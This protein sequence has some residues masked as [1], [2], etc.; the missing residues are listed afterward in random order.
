MTLWQQQEYLVFNRRF[1]FMPYYCVHSL[2]ATNRITKPFMTLWQ[3]QEY[4][5][6]NRRFPF[7]PYYCLHF[8]IAT[9]RIAMRFAVRTAP[10]FCYR[11]KRTDYSKGGT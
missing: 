4:L 10:P 6:F 3:Q 11:T 8:P 5:V 9:N 1:P 7:L 2:I